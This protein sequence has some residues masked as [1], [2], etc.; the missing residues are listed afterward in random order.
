MIN[1][2]MLRTSFDETVEKLK[3]L[4][5]N[6]EEFDLLFTKIVDLKSQLDIEPTL[7]HVP[8]ESIIKEYDF[9]HFKLYRT[10]KG[11]VFHMAG[12]N[13]VIPP[14]MQTLYGQLD[15]LLNQKDSYDKLS[16]EDKEMYDAVF[17]GTMSILMN[18]TICF[19][20]DK[21]WTDIALYVTS[22]QNELFEEMLNTPLMSEDVEADAKFNQDIAFVEDLKESIQESIKNKD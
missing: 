10:M 12:M 15:W 22:K 16:E 13:Q 7:V 8:I 1:R 18:P 3:E 11:I 9:G 17:G 21:Y 6:K 19:C 20:N 2:E 5:D 14:M 4:C